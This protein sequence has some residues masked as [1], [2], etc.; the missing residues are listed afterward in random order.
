MKVILGTGQLG[1]AIAET[2]LRQDRQQELL[3][4]N[5]RGKVAHPLPAHVQVV[6]ADVTSQYDVA[7]IAREAE[8]IYSCTD[9]PYHR[10][11][12]FYPA[13][14]RA[15]VYALGKTDARLVFADNLYSYGNVAGAAMHEG[16]PH[17]A[18]TRKGLVRREVINGLLH[19]STI[20]NRVAFVKAADFIGPHIHKGVL[21]TDFLDRLHSGKT[22]ALFGRP[23][24]PHTFTYIRDFAQAMVNVGDDPGASGRIWH[25]PNVPAISI[26]D[27]ISLFEQHTGL[28]ARTA[29]IPKIAVR[30]AGLFSRLPRELYELAYQLE[31]P[32]LV[33]HN[34]YAAA[35][36]YHA[37]DHN[38]IVAE[39]ISWYTNGY[40][41]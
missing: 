15:L 2:L 20:S 17:A 26:N 14:A 1:L 6:A 30:V 41:K 32:Y 9:V 5:R 38:T 19:D 7:C 36:G 4:V 3:L 31:Y 8:I 33:S 25:A 40:K 23:Q 16:M 13:A 21:A 28:R 37:T 24:L 18:R 35:F 27:W 22:I 11:S 39:T 10:W 29:R 12:S 34:Q